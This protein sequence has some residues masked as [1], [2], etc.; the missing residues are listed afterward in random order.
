MGAGYLIYLGLRMLLDRRPADCLAT[1]PRHDLARLF[2]DGVIVSL[3][4]PKI[5]MFFLAYLPQF[6]EP[7]GAPIPQ[8]ILLLGLLYVALALVT[9][10]AYALLA[11]SLRPWL[12][13]QALGGRLPRCLGGGVFVALG[14]NTALAGRQT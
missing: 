5:A 10:G 2:A 4:N 1:P 8:Q 7:T 6:V 9:D 12:G 11:G 14:V 13:R 3:F